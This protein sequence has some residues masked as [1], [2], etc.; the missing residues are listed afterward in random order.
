M[1][2]DLIR[3]K[4]ENKV[5][6]GKK[7]G[8]CGTAS[9]NY[10][11][12][13][14]P[15][16]RTFDNLTIPD[17]KTGRKEL[18]K[19]TGKSIIETV[20]KSDGK[21]LVLDSKSH[22]YA[23]HNTK[24]SEKHPGLGKRDLVQEI[25]DEAKKHRIVYVP[26]IPV[27]AD[28]RARRE[29]P[30]WAPV[31]VKGKVLTN[32]NGMPYC[33]LNSPFRYFMASYL[34]ELADN[35]DIGG[36]WFDGMGLMAAPNYC[37]CKWCCD[38]FK[39]R[40]RLDVPVDINKDWRIWVKW[41]EYRREVVREILSEFAKAGKE[42]KPGLP[43]IVGCG[44]HGW[45]HGSV[46]IESECDMVANEQL[47][48]WGTASVQYLRAAGRRPPEGYII[49]FQ[50]APSYPL[51]QP[52][53]EM[54]ARVMTTVANGGLPILYLCGSPEI[55]SHINKELSER[56]KWLMNTQNVPFCGIVLSEN[57]RDLHDRT[58]WAEPTLN[59][60]Y[61]T[62]RSLLEEKIPEQFLTDKDLE[63]DNL[64]DFAVVILPDVGVI[65][66]N[67]A[68]NL[69]R[70]VKKGGGLVATFK[71]SLCNEFGEIQ[72][73]FKLADLFG[74]HYAG[75][76]QETTEVKPW[77]G[78]IRDNIEIPNRQK[79]KFLAFDKHK[80]VN[81]PII[82]EAYATAISVAN[83]F[84]IP[85]VSTKCR[86][87]Y[88]DPML[89]VELEKD[90]EMVIWEDVQD[91]GKKWPL[92]VT[93]KYGKGRVVYI[94]A[95]L[96]RQYNSEFTWSHIRRMLTNSVRFVIGKK[97][98]PCGCEAPLHVQMTLFSQPDK[99]RIILHLL[100]DP[101]PKGLP[102]YRLHLF[103]R[104]KEEV[105]PIYN[106]KVWLKGHFKRIYT[107]PDRKNLKMIRDK[108]YTFVIVPKIDTHIMVIGE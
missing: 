70:Y 75:E 30:E 66:D 31:D 67:A 61:G 85:G 40:Y 55:F 39:K 80:I 37:Y 53:Q 73:N 49:A 59:A 12:L 33:C 46:T 38:G 60:C 9:K 50:Y 47:W 74:V 99:K 34:K 78:D 62:L 68:D 23:F 103:Q 18:S 43:V 41:I 58:E 69:R 77:F 98:P 42:A 101:N 96:G 91:K 8:G 86:L 64:D 16:G 52:L 102:P 105:V 26:Y 3:M 35:Y 10:S 97:Q 7:Y 17:T 108:G 4:V 27:N 57:S 2:E 51:T 92:I 15:Y 104:S 28:Y 72:K 81:D 45:P 56:A 76:L 24:I 106:I 84:V 100:N 63:E 90:A 29:H 54:R 95:E 107:A 87:V 88:P 94:S 11:W 19:I 36:F 48:Y 5:L 93:H 82:K 32:P 1:P 79:M 71:T 65:S 44:V 83:E 13:W 89:K 14:K 21:V 20:V 25:I 22:W 6:N